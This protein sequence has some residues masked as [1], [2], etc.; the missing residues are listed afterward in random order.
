MNKFQRKGLN[1]KKI[2]FLFIG[3]SLL[4][5]LKKD[6]MGT[7]AYAESYGGFQVEIG[8]EDI[9]WDDEAAP[10]LSETPTLP[11]KPE[12]PTPEL[13]EREM[14]ELEITEPETTELEVPEPEISEPEPPEPEAPESEVPELKAPELK[15]PEP[16]PSEPVVPETEPETAEL[17]TPELEVSEPKVSEPKVSEPTEPALKTESASGNLEYHQKYQIRFYHVKNVKQGECPSIFLLGTEDATVLSLR[18]NEKEVKW[19]MKNNQIF[20]EQP[21][22][23]EINKI[24][25]LVAVNGSTVIKMPEWEFSAAKET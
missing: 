22:E 25:L 9:F 2:C 18:L 21:I 7:Q 15:S 14:P 1:K 5:I 19:K 24:E 12:T 6:R 17:E 20:L 11:E 3:I 23:K 8:E 13:P 16:E 10:S 4:G